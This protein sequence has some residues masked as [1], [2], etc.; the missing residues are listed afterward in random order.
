M[1]SNSKEDSITE[2]KKT[3]VGILGNDYRVWGEIYSKFCFY[4]HIL[5]P[6]RKNNFPFMRFEYANRSIFYKHISD[7]F[8]GD[9][10]VDYFEFGVFKGESISAW[11]KINSNPNSCFFGFDS[12]EGL[13]EDWHSERLKGHFSVN[14]KA[15]S[16]EDARI[17]FIKGWFSDTLP[18]F[19]RRYREIFDVNKKLIIHMDAD[20]YSSTLYSLCKMDEFINVG[21]VILFDEFSG[22]PQDEFQA[23][24]DYARSHNRAY[25]VIAAREDCVKLAIQIT[26]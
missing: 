15:P 11:A 4:K 24:H 9:V 5:W 3:A 7:H 23:L 21:T 16:I 20:L 25:K 22:P 10:P 19:T 13:P 18:T 26:V 1:D 2:K 8:V 14:G 17:E 12:F 6:L